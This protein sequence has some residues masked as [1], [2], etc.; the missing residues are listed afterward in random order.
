[1]EKYD[2]LLTRAHAVLKMTFGYNEFRPM[3]QEVIVSVLSGRD[4]LAVM[5]TGGGKS[6]CYQ[7]PA[8]LF[9][10]ITLV[11][12]PNVKQPEISGTLTPIFPSSYSKITGYV[13][14]ILCLLV[15]F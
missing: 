15:L 10:G 7:I 2:E 1:M 11:V 4:T 8:L 9:G 6:L 12:S 3:Q 14:F 13:Y 5:P